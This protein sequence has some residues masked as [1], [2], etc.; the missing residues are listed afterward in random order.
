M[1]CLVTEPTSR[2]CVACAGQLEPGTTANLTS[3]GWL[4]HACDTEGK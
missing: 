1:R 3:Y 4:C 2:A